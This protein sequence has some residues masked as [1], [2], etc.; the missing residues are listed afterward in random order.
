MTHEA[1]SDKVI[2]HCH[3][4]GFMCVIIFPMAKVGSAI[5]YLIDLSAK[6]SLNME[7]VVFYHSGKILRDY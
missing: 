3:G 1:E 6:F 5:R 7:N 2:L 4:G